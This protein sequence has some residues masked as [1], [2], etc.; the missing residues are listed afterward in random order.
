MVLRSIKRFELRLSTS[1]CA[2]GLD[3]QVFQRV[4]E[5]APDQN[6]VIRKMKITDLNN[7]YIGLLPPFSTIFFTF[8]CFCQTDTL[9]FTTQPRRKVTNL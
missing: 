2:L 7:R 4:L 8:Q 1:D 9:R 3:R 6:A 5:R